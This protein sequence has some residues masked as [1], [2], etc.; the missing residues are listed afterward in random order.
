MPILPALLSA[1]PSAFS[2]I[3]GIGQRKR[4]QRILD[5]LQRPEYQTPDEIMSMLTL[6]Q[7]RASDPYSMAEMNARRDIGVSGANAV[8]AAQMGGNP[9]DVISGIVGQQG[10]SYNR[11]GAQ[12]EADQAQRQANLTNMLGTVAKYKDLEFEMNKYAPWLQ[13][14]NEGREMVGA[15]NQ[16]IF[17]GL[18]GLA[19]VGSLFASLPNASVPQ[20]VNYFSPQQAAGAVNGLVQGAQGIQNGISDWQLRAIMKAL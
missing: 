9:N 8:S 11:L 12:V 5:N 7:A 6:A 10:N 16:N 17:G 19:S 14:Y 2:L 18:N 15:G 4:G 1:I 13:K 3:Q 20:P